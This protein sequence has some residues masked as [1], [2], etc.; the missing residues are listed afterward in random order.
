MLEFKNP[1]ISIFNFKKM[2]LSI[3]RFFSV[4]P[5]FNLRKDLSALITTTFWNRQSS[6]SREAAHSSTWSPP[7]EPIK[8]ARSSTS[9]WRY[10]LKLYPCVSFNKWR[11][12]ISERSTWNWFFAPR[13]KWKR[14]SRCWV[15][16]DMPFT[17][18]G[19]WS[20]LLHLTFSYDT[21][22]YMNALYT[23]DV[24]CTV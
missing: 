12:T 24:F 11:R 7:E 17:D 15:L 10:Q 8:T 20:D 5:P 6:P 1:Q 13:D 4:T 9:K 16:T 3:G 19:E 22:G 21:L 23:R 14:I 18:Q 2:S